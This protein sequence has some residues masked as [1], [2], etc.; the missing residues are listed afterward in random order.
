MPG[1]IRAGVSAG[2]VS[3]GELGAIMQSFRH[4]RAMVAKLRRLRRRPD[5]ERIADQIRDF[6]DQE[7]YLSANPDVR[8]AGM[9]AALHYAAHGWREG[10]NPS[11]SFSTAEYCA[12]HPDL[13]AGGTNPLLHFITSLKK[14]RTSA[15]PAPEVIR[16]VAAEFDPSFYLAHY[17]DRIAPGATALDHFCQSGWRDGLDPNAAFSTRHYLATNPDVKACDIN[18][19]WHF[20]VAGRGE[21]RSPKP[22]RSWQMDLAQT[23]GSLDERRALWQQTDKPPQG[24]TA[25]ALAGLLA[26]LP[27][28]ANIMLSLS[29]DDYTQ[30]PGGVQLC[31]GRDAELARQ[32]GMTH[33]NLHPWQS[34]PTLAEEGS[35]PLLCMTL[36]GQPIGAALMSSISEA[37]TGLAKARVTL[38]CHHL[39]GHS[40]EGVLALAREN[41]L[42]SGLFWLH[43]YF[44]IC[45]SYT[46]MRNDLADCG[47]P[48]PA[49]NACTLCLYGAERQR[50]NRRFAALFET[51]DFELISPSAVA[52]DLW[53]ERGHLKASK[54]R[55]HP[56]VTLRKRPQ[57]ATAPVPTGPFRIAF[58]GTPSPHKGWPVFTD[59]H[60]RLKDDPGFEF[61]VFNTD[62]PLPDGM[63]QCRTHA[64]GALPEA[65]RDALAGH[66][67][68]LVIHWASWTETF[69]FSTHEAI[70]AG[71]FVITNP[72]AGNVARVVQDWEAGIV[73]D[74]PDGLIRMAENGALADLAGA[75]RLARMQHRFE[76]VFSTMSHTATSGAILAA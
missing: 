38:V 50:Q 28:P 8:Q 46:L 55:L 65:T 49:S 70:G 5:H 23:L 34:L 4:L 48:A 31:I 25:T 2:M 11:A 45:T 57:A 67:I 32:T 47:A 6:V 44:S 12:R 14:D 19:F 52:L 37:L 24:M 62:G 41:Q 68:D 61:W 1:R 71:A 42:R 43:D 20:L 21:G 9:D 66:E 17:G 63:H 56:H 10:R 74:T 27:A 35:D 18:P 59:L 3:I 73:I 30:V 60:E 76:M 13:R 22:D 53:T 54:T 15:L 26:D 40:I 16:V 58:V 72:G 7:Y 29:H 64:S 69:S 33:L 36:D 75:A 51:L 39:A